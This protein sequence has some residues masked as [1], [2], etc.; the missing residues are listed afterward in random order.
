MLL[1]PDQP[2]EANTRLICATGEH[3]ALGVAPNLTPCR[4]AFTLDQR[5]CRQ[6]VTVQLTQREHD[7]V[8]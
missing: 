4:L 8:S 1:I 2:P 6:G 3:S 5:V 7:D